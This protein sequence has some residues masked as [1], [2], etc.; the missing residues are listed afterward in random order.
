VS[1]DRKRLTQ[2]CFCQHVYV[3]FNE[4]TIV[5]RASDAIRLV[6]GR[7]LS[8]RCKVFVSVSGELRMRYGQLIVYKHK[9]NTIF[10]Y[11]Q[12]FMSNV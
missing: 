12:Q 3:A 10:I 1:I 4:M 7:S 8:M 9:L 5:I 11:I 6:K 2:L